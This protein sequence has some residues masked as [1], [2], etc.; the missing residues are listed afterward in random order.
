MV[1]LFIAARNLDIRAI[2][3]RQLKVQE[4][5]FPVIVKAFR[6]QNGVFHIIIPFANKIEAL[7]TVTR[8]ELQLPGTKNNY[9]ILTVYL[10]GYQADHWHLYD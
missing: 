8:Y 6:C 10:S 2:I 5:T 3:R 7:K 9:P 1:L 4:I